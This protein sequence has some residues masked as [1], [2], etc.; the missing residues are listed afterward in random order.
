MRLD[1]IHQAVTA[2]TWT[3]IETTAAPGALDS[4]VAGSNDAE[5]GATGA[6]TAEMAVFGQSWAQESA[7]RPRFEK[8]YINQRQ[9]AR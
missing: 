9:L 5:T 6:A 8:R 7:Q 3:Q 1:H 2:L 4:A